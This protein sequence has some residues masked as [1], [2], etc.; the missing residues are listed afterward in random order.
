MHALLK[1]IPA[2]PLLLVGQYCAH[3]CSHSIEYEKGVQWLQ[4]VRAKCRC[5]MTEMKRDWG[6][7][8]W[9]LSSPPE[10]RLLNVDHPQSPANPSENQQN[11]QPSNDWFKNS[12]ASEQPPI[13]L[14]G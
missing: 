2:L 14:F 1:A 8:K 4:V 7:G 5:P 9:A 10:K 12:P 3:R 6:G 11:A 13:Y